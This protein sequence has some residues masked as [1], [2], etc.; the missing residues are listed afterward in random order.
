M[1]NPHLF[2]KKYSKKLESL[3]EQKIQSEKL[4]DNL[5]IREYGNPKSYLLE[6]DGYKL[7]KSRNPSFLI[8]YLEWEIFHAY[9]DEISEY[10]S[11]FHSA[12]VVKD[13]KA[14]LLVGESGKG[15]TTLTL[16]LIKRGFHYLSDDQSVVHPEKLKILPAPKA[17]HLKGKSLEFFPSL[18]P[19]FVPLPYPPKFF[20]GVTKAL[21]CFPTEDILPA[22]DTAF[23][24]YFILFLRQGETIKLQPI[25]KSHAAAQFFTYSYECDLKDFNTA[26]QLTRK[27]PAFFLTVGELSPTCLTIERL[28]RGETNV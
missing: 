7:I 9:V 12:S 11:V 16:A 19:E 25:P 28:L 15:K 21:C 18:S 22:L 8:P 4:T 3:S 5:T 24:I 1:I 17:L 20:P 27:V 23:S 6:R 2:L 13:G 26:V 14:I 10:L